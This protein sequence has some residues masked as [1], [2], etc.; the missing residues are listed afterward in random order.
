L[1]ASDIGA[2][3]GREFA[4]ATLTLTFIAHLIVED[5][6]LHFNTLVN[7]IVL[8]LNEASGNGSDVALLIRKCHTT[9]AL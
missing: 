8:Q 1:Q 7:V 9:S 5:V 4:T 3:E 2:K 6:R